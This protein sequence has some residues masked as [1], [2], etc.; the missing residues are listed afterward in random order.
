MTAIETRRMTAV[1]ARIADIVNGS[2]IKP[3]GLQPAVVVA[4]SGRRLGR[5]RVLATVSEKY[6]SVERAFASLTLDDA[7]ATIR[8]KIFKALSIVENISVGDRVDVIGKVREYNGEVY[9]AP[10][11]VVRADD[12]NMELLRELELREE[13]KRFEEKRRLVREY[14]Q[15]AAD[16]SELKQMLETQFAISPETVDDIVAS[17]P[18]EEA[19]ASSDKEKILAL[20]TEIDKGQ[21]ADYADLLAASGLEE[22]AVDKAINELLEEGACFEPRPGKIRRL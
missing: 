18:I 4:P 3:E 14:Q 10:E 19:A 21:G 9:I 13:E 1:K 17:H 22:S 6:V 7:T 12:P 15:Q 2:Y 5:V 11:T 20:I 16:I 8:A